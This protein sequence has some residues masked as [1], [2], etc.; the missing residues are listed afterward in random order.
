MEEIK[1]IKLETESDLDLF[2]NVAKIRIVV[3]SDKLYIIP[4]KGFQEKLS[5]DLKRIEDFNIRQTVG[6]A[7]F[8][9]KIDGSFID[10][11]RFTNANRYKFSRFITQ[12]KNLKSG[13]P[14]S[15][16]E[17]N[18]SNP[19]LCSKC[20]FPLQ[21]EESQCPNCLK[22]G[23]IL[24]R[25]FSLL[26]EHIGWIFIIF[27]LMII[28]VALSLVPPRITKILVDEVLTTKKHIDWLPY[29][30]I[31][32]VGAEFFRAQINM[33]V[34]TISASVGTLITNNLRKRMFKKLEE[35]SLNYYDINS[36]G[37][38]MTRFSSD[39]EAFHGF[40]TQAGQGF[41]LNIFMLIGI[42][43]MLFSINSLLALYV[44]IPIPFVIIGTLVFWQGIYPKYFKVWDSQVK[45]ST[46][47]NNVLSGIK[48]VKAFSQ[49]EKEFKRFTFY[50]DKLKDSVRTVNINIS[51]FNPLMTFLFSLGGLIIWYIG[52]KS[53]L[54]GRLTLG[55]LMAFLSYIGMFYSP[56]THL[57]LLS[58]WFSNFT[59]ASHRIF[60]V[61]DT[62]PQVKEPKKSVKLSHVKGSIEFK[63]VTF[64]YD[65]YQPVLKNV[66]FKIEP[67]EV[68][69][70]VGRSGSGK[71]TIVNLLCKFYDVQQGEILI[72]G[73][74]IREISSYELRKHIGL[75]LQEPFT[76]RGTIAENISY[77]KPDASFE[78]II[79]SA[80]I[81]NAHEFIM[82]LPNGYDTL[83][84]EKGAG[85][86]GG[87][88]QRITIARAVLCNPSILI[89]DEATSSVD[90]ES[91]K[92]IQDA[93]SLL[94]KERTTIIIAHRLSTL[95]ESDKI[96][97][98]DGGKI[99]EIGNHN[100][101]MERKGLYYNLIVMQTQL[102]NIEE[103]L[104][105]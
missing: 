1:D 45:I 62:E 58:T 32:L 9:I 44:M 96:I 15:N 81:A 78:E 99:V 39:V 97:V 12:I 67:G 18:K 23:A 84:G 28:G 75:V 65:P 73:K 14:F 5:F 83:L 105:R 25:V 52:G 70:I 76:F 47:L 91:E 40:V 17:L 85:L 102:A 74:D 38:I 19:L 82:K 55:E 27:F 59:T 11:F 71:T 30:V 8:Q 16:E 64:G 72:D 88:R 79:Y 48:T 93:L 94:W 57:T 50:A 100:E 34:G 21:T 33:L 31:I 3:T 37:T 87:E 2:G 66:S 61:L 22:Q 98:I 77:G 4:E 90:T 24:I 29:L 36:V 46:F 41:L 43:I 86:S 42:G 103:S 92:K 101:L 26:S 69:G 7:F 60:E 10:I 95:K 104:I 51:V 68:V 54:E 35:L 56:L 13:L 80:K 6:S 53:V 63:N 20:G 89:L 49:E